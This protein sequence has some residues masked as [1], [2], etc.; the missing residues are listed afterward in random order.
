MRILISGFI[1]D[2]QTDI[3]MIQPNQFVNSQDPDEVWESAQKPKNGRLEMRQGGIV[4]I[5]E[6][7]RGGLTAKN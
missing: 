6:G 4:Q 3:N 2:D 5:F 7:V 1:P